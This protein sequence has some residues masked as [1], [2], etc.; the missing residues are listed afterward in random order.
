MVKT[1]VKTR[2][3]TSIPVSHAAGCKFC[4][5]GEAA[6]SFDHL[7]RL[8]GQH[9]PSIPAHGGTAD[10]LCP[11]HSHLAVKT[12]LTKR[13]PGSIEH[14]RRVLLPKEIPFQNDGLFSATSLPA[15]RGKKGQGQR[16]LWQSLLLA[17]QKPSP[18]DLVLQVPRDFRK[19]FHPHKEQ[20]NRVS[21]PGCPRHPLPSSRQGCQPHA[22]RHIPVAPR[23]DAEAKHSLTEKHPGGDSSSPAPPTG[24]PLA[25]PGCRH[26][27]VPPRSTQGTQRVPKRSPGCPSQPGV[28]GVPTPRRG[29]PGALPFR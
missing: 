9:L 14:V 8:R 20:N 11:H 29:A 16:R 25:P 28:P 22:H 5:T 2:V 24:C 13:Y 6:T 26:G 17:L 27:A 21:W 19:G 7:K 10:I 23:K 4:N 15:Q 3:N 18:S 12:R 1:S